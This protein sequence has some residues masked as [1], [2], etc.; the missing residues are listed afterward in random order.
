MRK[1]TK[2]KM[3]GVEGK[4][5]KKSLWMAFVCIDKLK[6]DVWIAFEKG[7]QNIKKY[8]AWVIRKQISA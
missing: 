5:K 6:R 2:R 8:Y 4:K 7:K 3:D 1:I